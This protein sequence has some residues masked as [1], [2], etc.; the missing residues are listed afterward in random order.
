ME[1]LGVFML[2][3]LGLLR[4]PTRIQDHLSL[5]IA[6]A[7]L[8][9]ENLT[10]GTIFLGVRCSDQVLEKG[11]PKLVQ[12]LIFTGHDQL[13]VLRRLCKGMEPV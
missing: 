1:V 13:E 8:E 3:S 11:Q 2:D 5:P 4:C 7:I 10:Y 6:H 9:I 12:Y